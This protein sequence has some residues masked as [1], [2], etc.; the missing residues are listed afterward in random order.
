MRWL[1]A[2]KWEENMSA[3]IKIGRANHGNLLPGILKVWILPIIISGVLLILAILLLNLI[4][5]G[6]FAPYSNCN[7]LIVT[8]LGMDPFFCDGYTVKFLETTIFTLPGLK[9]AMDPSLER[10]RSAAAWSVVLFFAC[11][12]LF[13]A[14]IINNLKTIVEL[15]RLNKEEWKKFM[16]GVRIGLFIFVV[17]C[18]VFYF[19]VV[20]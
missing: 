11:I 9:G 8:K 19:A 17:F 12:S 14:I 18:A 5:K 10:I 7:Y 20:K 13:L 3:K 4:I 15:I 16:A 6:A 2:D 1:A